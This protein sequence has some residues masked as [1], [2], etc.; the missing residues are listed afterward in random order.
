[1]GVNNGLKKVFRVHKRLIAYIL[2]SVSTQWA[3]LLGE[4]SNVGV[5]GKVECDKVGRGFIFAL[6]RSKRLCQPREFRQMW[7]PIRF[8][9]ASHGS[10]SCIG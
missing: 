10:F 4:C 2:E 7:C 9:D 5:D 6:V 3:R 8:Q 1:M